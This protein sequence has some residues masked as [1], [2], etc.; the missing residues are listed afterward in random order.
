MDSLSQLAL[1]AAVGV[2]AMG[3]RTAPWKAAAWGAL[4]GTLPDLDV[5]VD[6]GD[7]LSNMVKHRAHSHA[8][9]WLTLLTPPLAWLIARLQRERALWPRWCL[10]VWLAL[11]TH[12]L[13]D[14]LTVYGTQLA[15]P[16]SDHPYGVGSVFIIDP[17]Y[18]LPLLIG[19]VLALA[20]QRRRPARALWANGLGLL[21]S[22]TYLAW[23]VAAQ[24]HVST[25]ARASLARQGVQAQALLV[26]P[27]P[28]NSVLWR[29]VAT[30]PGHYHEGFYSLL[31]GTPEPLWQVHDRGLPLR[32]AYAQDPSLQRLDRFAHGLTAMRAVDG[33]AWVSDLRM[34]QTPVFSFS[35]DLGPAGG[36]AATPQ[37]PLPRGGRPDIG[38]ALAWLWARMGGQRLPP[39]G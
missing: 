4:C 7:A 27:T 25:L 8:L 19:L 2:A 17:L 23:G 10:A 26:T 20:W 3:R 24:Q 33:R 37:P 5:F 14:T 9:F 39:P 29:V 6:H 30:T 36:P 35:F 31:D 38:P 16:F 11:V 13:L 18:T 34:G 32:Q 15:Q 28:F 1:G 21:L 22:T 12:P